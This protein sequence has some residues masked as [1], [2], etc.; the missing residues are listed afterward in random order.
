MFE[1]QCFFVV[2]C[3]AFFVVQTLALYQILE[4]MFHISSR[5]GQSSCVSKFG[6]LHSQRKIIWQIIKMKALEVLLVMLVIV[7]VKKTL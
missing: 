3:L 6:K 4:F 7:L 5:C 1:K 2:Q